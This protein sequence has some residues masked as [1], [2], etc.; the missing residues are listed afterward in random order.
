MVAPEHNLNMQRLLHTVVFFC[1]VVSLPVARDESQSMT[2]FLVF[3]GCLLTCRC[4]VFL[5]VKLL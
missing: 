2:F 4:D 3:V 5:D 1:F